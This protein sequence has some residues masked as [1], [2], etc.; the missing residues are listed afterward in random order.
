MITIFR[1][2]NIIRLNEI[3]ARLDKS[4]ST[5]KAKLVL[6]KRFGLIRS[7]K[8]GY[9][10]TEKFIQFLN[11]IEQK[12]KATSALPPHQNMTPAQKMMRAHR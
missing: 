2:N 11:Q 10:K 3:S 9:A 1:T 4:D 8:S 6:F 7:G 5:I 12:K